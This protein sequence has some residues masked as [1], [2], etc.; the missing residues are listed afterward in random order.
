MT[1][2]YMVGVPGDMLDHGVALRNRARGHRPRFLFSYWY[3]KDVDIRAWITQEFPL[4][5]VD[6]FVDGGGFSAD[7]QGGTI[8]FDEYT[9]WLRKY[10]DLFLTYSN[11]DVIGDQAGTDENQLIL[12]AM[13]LHP[14]PV[15]TLQRSGAD[16][17]SLQM[18]LD[19]GYE[20]IALGGCVPFAG[21]TRKLMPHLIKCF[22]LAESYPTVFHG[23]GINT[24]EILKSLPFYSA[25]ASSWVSGMKFG[26]MRLFDR[27]T[28]KLIQAQ[29][30]QRDS[31]MA[32]AHIIR[33]AGFD[34]GIFVDRSA[35][36]RTVLELC[37]LSLLNMELYLRRLHGT[38]LMPLGGRIF[39]LQKGVHYD[40]HFT[41][42]A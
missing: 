2:L 24:W 9:A 27:V 12:E 19:S 17:R 22:R 28:G 25:D 39:N 32:A 23:F 36:W 29:L 38:V 5:P 13:G 3:F 4:E 15:F 8:S 35:H 16:Y 14:F 40:H 30:G 33:D 18:Y 11:F 21:Q 1:K 6:I 7:S 20:Y 31:V 41:E 37:G 10:S 34:P 26:S 42:V